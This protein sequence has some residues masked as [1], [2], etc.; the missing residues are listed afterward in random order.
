M[1]SGGCQ[2]F[3]T[4]QLSTIHSLFLHLF[5]ANISYSCPMYLPFFDSQTHKLSSTIKIEAL[6][7]STDS[8][9]HRNIRAFLVS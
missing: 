2:F 6:A 9:L 7:F 3:S 5:K 1:Q 4:L 8:A